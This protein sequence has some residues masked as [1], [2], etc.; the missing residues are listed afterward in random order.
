MDSYRILRNGLIIQ[1]G[2]HE[3]NGRDYETISLHLG[4]SSIDSYGAYVTAVCNNSSYGNYSTIAKK[5]ASTIELATW[6]TIDSHR[7]G[8]RAQWFTIGY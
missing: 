7:N 4:Y 1:W 6:N 5:S 2:Y 3:G 8:I